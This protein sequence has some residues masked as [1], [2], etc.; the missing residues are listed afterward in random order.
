MAMTFPKEQFRQI[1]A[2]PSQ[3]SKGINK[4]QKSMNEMKS[5]KA[6]FKQCK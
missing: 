3:N 1:L 2:L 6:D 4:L 5:A